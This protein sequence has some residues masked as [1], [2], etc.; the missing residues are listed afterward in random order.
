M[1]GSAEVKIESALM[2]ILIEVIPVK[3]SVIRLNLKIPNDLLYFDGHFD[4]ASLLAGVVQIDWAVMFG[5]EYFPIF[6]EFA[7]LESMKFQQVI[8]PGANI[9][10]D[11]QYNPD[12][13][14]LIFKYW[15]EGKDFSF[16][17]VVF[18]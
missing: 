10:L 8:A 3:D 13:Q 1:F 14:K 17:R 11:L 6:G 4:Q 5:R 9:F 16:G 15:G 7:G 12:K 2:P 18:S